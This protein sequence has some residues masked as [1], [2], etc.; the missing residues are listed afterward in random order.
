[1]TV[2]L[3]PIARHIWDMKYRRTADDGTPLETSVADTWD[4]VAD[5][6]AGAEPASARGE[7]R[8][9]FREALA[10]FRV[11][12]AGRILAGAGTGLEVTLFNCFVMGTLP[13]D[14][15]GIFTHLREAAE[16]LRAGGGI[17]YDFSTLRPEGAPVH[18]LG[19][20][21]SGPV[22]FMDVWDAMCRT[23]MSAGNR[24]GAM[25]GT[26]RC[27]H[28][29]IETFIAAKGDPERLRMF[30]LSVLVTDAFMD[31]VE[32][33][34]DWP[35]VFNGET[36]RTVRARELWDRIMA[37][38]YAYAE[39]GVIF[40]DRVNALNNLAYCETIH[41]TNPCGEEPLPPYGACLLGSINLARLVKHPFTDAAE[42]DVDALDE[43]VP[44]AVRMLDDAIEVSRYPLTRQREE[45]V[46]KRRI[47]LGVTGLGDA[48]MMCGLTYG[49]DA[50]V[51][52]TETWLH[53]LQRRS[54]LASAELARERGAFPLFERDAFLASPTVRGLDADVRDAIAKHGVR[55]GLVGSVA[56]TGTISLLADNVSSGLE[57][58]Y[59]PSYTRKLLEPDGNRRTVTVTD[60]GVAAYRRMTG[61]DSALPPAFIDTESLSP[62]A[63][64]AMQAAVQRYID[65]SVSK[66]INVPADIPFERFKDVYR[67]AYDAGCKGCTTYRPNP[68]TG[69]VLETG[70]TTQTNDPGLDADVPCHVCG[71]RATLGHPGCRVCAACGASRCGV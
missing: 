31:A 37:A 34:D 3:S 13:D 22:S 16:T 2:E 47:G 51:A 68:T 8:R 60:F 67:E 50:A 61:D 65:A 26:L 56:P 54:Y 29:D 25:M 30:N 32:A 20:T 28:P 40:I 33:G 36:L 17:G 10:D 71:A 49:G 41:A 55:N 14:L 64:V 35:L 9:A 52:R 18:G 23:I 45:A 27:D 5:A 6:L 53:A 24:R 62:Q 11:M 48:L 12:P 1:M 66:T 7:H 46:A 57:P 70:D 15:H 59:S 43:L 69:A 63:H 42:L 19:G 58:I 39:P 21:A 38:T 44:R 4:R